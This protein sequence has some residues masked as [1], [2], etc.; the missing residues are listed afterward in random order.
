[1]TLSILTAPTKAPFL[2]N[3]TLF[4]QSTLS[5]KRG[6]YRFGVDLKLILGTQW[7]H[8]GFFTFWRNRWIIKSS[9]QQALAQFKVMSCFLDSQV[10]QWTNLFS[11]KSKYFGSKKWPSI[12][13]NQQVNCSSITVHVSGLKLC[14]Q[15]KSISLIL[16]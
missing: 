2:R 9:S 15:L 1:M 10:Q 8:K 7:G 4:P 5:G 11:C 14:S 3:D 12:Y 16:I 13:G 6:L